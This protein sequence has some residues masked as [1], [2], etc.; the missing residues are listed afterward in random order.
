MQPL[1]VVFSPRAEAQLSVI[2]RDLAGET[3]SAIE[4]VLHEDPRSAYLRQNWSNQFYTFLIAGLHV[5][6]RFDDN[7]HTVSVFRINVAGKLCECGS[8]EWQCEQ[9]GGTE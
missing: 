4:S 2:K 9:H 6:C 3:K 8:L 1:E 5:S 7:A